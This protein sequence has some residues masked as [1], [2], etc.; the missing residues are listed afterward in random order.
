MKLTAKYFSYGLLCRSHL[1]LSN[2]TP[3]NL[4]VARFNAVAQN[5]QSGTTQNA[6]V[7]IKAK[8]EIL[9]VIELLID[10]QPNDVADLLIEVCMPWKDRS[11]VQNI[12]R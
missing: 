4:Q 1:K 10:K 8:P 9:R 6:T 3:M 5:P 11:L 12:L 2:S 7:L